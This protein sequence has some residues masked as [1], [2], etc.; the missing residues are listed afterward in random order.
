MP[1]RFPFR[2]S[3]PANPQII[4]HEITGK[5]SEPAPA[6]SLKA[7]AV[8]SLKAR[9]A[10]TRS[11]TMAKFFMD[12]ERLR[13]N[14]SGWQEGMVIFKPIF[15]WTGIVPIFSVLYG[16]GVSAMFGKQYGIAIGLVILALSV[17]AVK[18][19]SEAKNWRQS[20]LIFALCLLFMLLHLFWIMRS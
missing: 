20:L 9:A 1:G 8:Q 14:L 10:A 7:R 5:G 11:P 2:S 18:G 3:S 16:A 6:A 17:L 15:S 13:A 19:M 4:P 12:I